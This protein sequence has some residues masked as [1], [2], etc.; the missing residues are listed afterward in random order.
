MSDKGMFGG[1]GNLGN[2]MKQAQAMQER[3]AKVQAERPNIGAFL[4][5]SALVSFSGDVVTIGFPA[6]ASAAMKTIQ[7]KGAQQA[8]EDACSALS[9][10]RVRVSIAALDGETAAP[11]VAKLRREREATTE[12]HL[13]EEV[14]ANPL[15]K[16]V[17]S[18]FGGEVKEVRQNQ[19]QSERENKG[20][21]DVR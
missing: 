18:V 7:Q 17:L 15:V 6:S 11:T 19:A 13:R 5:E 12:R 4:E 21:G 2:I 10:R 1:M 3:L 14:L 8:V 20:D 9:G 16:E